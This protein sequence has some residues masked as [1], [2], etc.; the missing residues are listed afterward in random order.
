MSLEIAW[1]QNI[2]VT[3][4]NLLK[5]LLVVFGF[6]SQ[7]FVCGFSRQNICSVDQSSDLRITSISGPGQYSSFG[8]SRELPWSTVSLQ[9]SSQNLFCLGDV[10]GQV[11]LLWNKKN[12]VI[13]KSQKVGIALHC[14]HKIVLLHHGG[15][16]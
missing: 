13:R 14:T 16:F 9:L 2:L 4:S 8:K 5:S 15:T 11:H 12:N 6:G 10:S 7:E 3:D 1:K